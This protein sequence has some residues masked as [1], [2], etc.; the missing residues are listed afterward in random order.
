MHDRPA[1]VES[2]EDRLIDTII[3]AQGGLRPQ[4]HNC[5]KS[6]S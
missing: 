3:A 1:P 2:D 6:A 4:P 5:S